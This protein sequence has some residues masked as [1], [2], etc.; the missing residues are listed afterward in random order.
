M[1]NHWKSKCKF[2]YWTNRHSPHSYLK[3]VGNLTLTDWKRG[4]FTKVNRF[5]KDNPFYK[6]TASP[7]PGGYNLQEQGSLTLSNSKQ[8]LNHSMSIKDSKIFGS[9]YDKYKNVYYSELSKDF[10]N[11]E[12]P[13]PAEY[14][15]KE[16]TQSIYKNQAKHKFATSSRWMLIKDSASKSPNKTNRSEYFSSI[17]IKDF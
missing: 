10:Q 1:F 7:G 16:T 8:S 14:T 4:N 9:T 15:P 11:R 12:G 6:E 17:L 2:Y 5:N 13:G 3:T